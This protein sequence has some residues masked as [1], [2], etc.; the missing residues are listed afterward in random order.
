MRLPASADRRGSGRGA[1]NTYAIGDVQG[2][3]DPLRRLLDQVGF[4]PACDRLWFTGDL[5]NRG[6][7]SLETLRFVRSL[8]ER[9]V[10]V[11]GN[12][13][14]HLLAAA[15]TGRR[16]RRD[17]LDDVLAAPDRDELLAWLRARPLLHFD[18]E[19]AL[20][21]VH[22]GLVPQWDTAQARVLAREAEALIAGP[23]GDTFLREHMYGNEPSRW[24]EALTGF[25]RA[26]F[27][28]NVMTRLRFCEAD[29]R[30]H[31]E[32][33]GAVGS[34]P[35]GLLPWFAVPKR[36]SGEAT[37]LFGHWSALGR[38]EW[39]EHRV[40]GLDTGAVWGRGLSALRLEDRR[41]FTVKSPR[42]G[43]D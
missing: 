43:H 14:L 28:V 21:L 2:C 4:D 32:I 18:A 24:N 23:D 29:G 12:H 40:Y 10:V 20:L 15:L 30:I 25:P 5:V 9:A 36:A 31:L 3:Y 8:G 16:N 11:L 34:Q 7:Q 1:A 39:P 22:A 35:R 37:I 26:R 17:T 19:R 27:V 38:V 41:L 6:P 13:D 42:Y 33:K